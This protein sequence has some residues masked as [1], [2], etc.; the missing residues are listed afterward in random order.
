VNLREAQ[1]L[2]KKLY[3]AIKEEKTVAQEEV[4]R[5]GEFLEKNRY[6]VLILR[7]YGVNY[8]PEDK[9]MTVAHY[10]VEEYDLYGY[11]HYR[12]WRVRYQRLLEKAGDL[13]IERLL[14]IKRR[15][16]IRPCVFFI[17]KTPKLNLSEPCLKG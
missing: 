5:L 10:P 14:T 6:K 1:N 8:N 15:L 3:Y 13:L 7:E 11:F 9:T 12:Y 4:N 17:Y 16:D 2:I